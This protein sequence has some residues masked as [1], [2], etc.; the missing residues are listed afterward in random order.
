MIVAASSSVNKK[1]YAPY[2]HVKS[3]AQPRNARWQIEE[4]KIAKI[5]RRFSEDFR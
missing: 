3:R 4:E 1:S 2:R 5:L